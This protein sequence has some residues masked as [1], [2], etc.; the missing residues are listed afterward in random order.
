M[1]AH[2]GQPLIN[3]YFEAWDYGPV[4]PTVYYEFREY[5]NGPIRRLAYTWQPSTKQTIVA[6]PPIG[7]S[8][9]DEV[10]GW[11]WENYKHYSGGDLSRMTHKAGSPWDIARKKA[12][13]SGM[14]NE[15]LEFSDIQRHFSQLTNA[16]AA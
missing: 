8:D 15:R 10:I 5:K 3:E 4:A 11:V 12:L 16:A 2:D 7:D 6:P 14:R 1:A 9:A 13:N